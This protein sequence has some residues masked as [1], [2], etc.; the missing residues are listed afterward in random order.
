MPSPGSDACWCR[1]ERPERQQRCKMVARPWRKESCWPLRGPAWHTKTSNEH[2]PYGNKPRC[3][4]N[5]RPAPGDWD[6]H[7]F[8]RY[9]NDDEGRTSENRKDNIQSNGRHWEPYRRTAGKCQRT[10][11][12]L[13]LAGWRQLQEL[14]LLFSHR[15]V[16]K[17]KEMVPYWEMLL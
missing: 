3:S 13:Y 14:S 17:Y 16:T 8:E 2:A 10:W 1:Q 6:D 7:V 12:T 9:P 5:A 4:R 11:R 15:K